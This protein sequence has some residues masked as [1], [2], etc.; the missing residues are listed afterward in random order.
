VKDILPYLRVIFEANVEMA[1]GIAKWLDVDESMIKYLA[2][3]EGRAK[4]ILGN[5]SG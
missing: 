5:I 1:A 4:A 3:N 2:G